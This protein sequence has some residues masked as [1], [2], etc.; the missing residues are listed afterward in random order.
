MQK[1]SVISPIGGFGNHLRWLLMLDPKFNFKFT[2]FNISTSQFYSRQWIAG[3]QFPKYWSITYEKFCQQKEEELDNNLLEEYI[4]SFN[5]PHLDFSSTQQK[6]KSIEKYVYHKNRTWHNWLNTEW[7]FRVHLMP[8]IGFEH[9]VKLDYNI[10]SDQKIL[11]LMPEYSTTS[12]RAYLK[13]NSH[14]NN[15]TR[16]QFNWQTEEFQTRVKTLLASGK[17]NICQ[18][19][20]ETLLNPVL[21]KDFYQTAI[22]HFGLSDCYDHANYVHGLWYNL[23]KQSESDLLFNLQK[24]YN[25]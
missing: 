10:N 9:H 3:Q 12:L 13:F 4:E 19:Y 15:L 2:D 1:F 25:S 21:N 5:L 22:N 16:E 17:S 23:Q 7:K 20:S 18:L 8:F 11:F 24:F 6:I 14:L